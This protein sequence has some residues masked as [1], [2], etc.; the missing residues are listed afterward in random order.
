MST[1][2]SNPSPSRFAVKR[3]RIKH[4][5]AMAAASALAVAGLTTY[6]LSSAGAAT[7]TPAQAASAQSAFAFKLV[8]SPGIATGRR[9]AT[10]RWRRRWQRLHLG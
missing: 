4:G 2:S 8:P 1:P 9:R 5:L 7:S 3:P 10:E 6:G